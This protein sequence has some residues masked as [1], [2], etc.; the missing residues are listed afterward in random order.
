[1]NNDFLKKR[2]V[3]V[4]AAALL[5]L[6]AGLFILKP[7][8]KKA[9]P[10]GVNLIAETDFSHLRDGDSAWYE[11]AYVRNEAYTVFSFDEGRTEGSAATSPT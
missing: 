1:M 11:D 10:A 4:L 5:L 9:T 3:P 8:Q 6:A 7:W 2:W